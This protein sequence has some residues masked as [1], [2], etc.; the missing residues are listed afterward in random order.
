M[1]E[2][3]PNDR[4]VLLFLVQYRVMEIDSNMVLEYPYV[5]YVQ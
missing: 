5:R 4:I 1:Y 2:Y 3:G